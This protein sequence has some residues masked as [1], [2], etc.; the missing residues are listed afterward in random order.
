MT[1]SAPA[2]P[3]AKRGPT[4]SEPTAGRWVGGALVAN[5]VVQ[6]LIVVTGGL[7]RLTGSGLG[8]PTWP[9]CVPGSYTPVVQQPQGVH[10]YIEFGNRTL[11][12]VVGVAALAALVGVWLVVRRAGR[13]RSLLAVAALPLLGVVVQAVLGGITVLTRL[14]PATVAAHFLVSAAIVAA[15]TYLLWRV[16]E[17]DGP[18]V[19][20]VAVEVRWLG[21][22]L[23]ALTAVVLLL[24][25]LVTGSGPRSGDA[26]APA[27]FGFDP[28]TMSWL[29]SD[30][31]L[32]W[33]GILLALIVALRLT[34]APTAV[35]RAAR[36]TLL[37]GLLQGAIGYLQ[38]LTGL[39]VVAVALHMLGASLLVIAVTRLTLSLRVRAAA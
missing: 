19:A 1:S 32:V 27:R 15:S 13:R 29:H 24:G 6:V 37:V 38:Y 3:S 31:V 9:Q 20:V 35:R 12:S 14:H 10:K 39:P 36:V 33:F 30:A 23:V 26:T 16:R 34:G 8:C 17:G 7:V 25:T 11:T 4:S 21:R 2:A 22:A 28:R 5:L 18:A